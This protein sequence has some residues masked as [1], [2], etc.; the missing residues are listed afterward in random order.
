MIP[1]VNEEKIINKYYKAVAWYKLNKATHLK[2]AFLPSQRHSK[3]QGMEKGFLNQ[4]FVLSG[5]TN[6]RTI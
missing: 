4:C 5:K 3:D 2:K 1:N 6:F